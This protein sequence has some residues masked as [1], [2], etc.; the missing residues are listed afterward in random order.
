MKILI[1][2]SN[3]IGDTILSTGIVEYF[4]QNYPK[5]KFTFLIGPSA[6]QVYEHFPALEKIITIK[7]QKFNLHWLKM[8]FHCFNIKWD[9]IIDL[10]SSLIS[11][12][13]LSDKKYIFKKYKDIYHIEQL[14]N[15]FNLKNSNLIIY[16]DLSELNIV[17]NNLDENF[18]YV[19]MVS[20]K[21]PY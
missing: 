7:K 20:Y 19:V 21:K 16:N 12:F 14:N 2:S 10:R 11:Y 13:L 18:K 3:L 1:I 15:Y 9:I 17:K 8:Y 5:A 6:G 4:H